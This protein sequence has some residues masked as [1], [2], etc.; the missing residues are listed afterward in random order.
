MP[1]PTT[2]PTPRHVL[3]RL[4]TMLTDGCELQLA[5]GQHGDDL[6]NTKNEISELTRLIQRIRSEIENVKK[7]VQEELV[8]DVPGPLFQFP[9]CSGEMERLSAQ[10]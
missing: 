4:V 10:A 9:H 5:A 2:S 6:K 3:P 7:Q 1:C 8:R